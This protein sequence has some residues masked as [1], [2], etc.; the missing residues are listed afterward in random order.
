MSGVAGRPLTRAASRATV[1]RPVKVRLSRS[2][3]IVPGFGS[4]TMTARYRAGSMCSAALRGGYHATWAS[5][6]S[7][8]PP[9]R[10]ATTAVA[11]VMLYAQAGGRTGLMSRR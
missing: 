11:T 1:R 7:S 2:G 3:L 4:M 9:P 10:A 6:R 5:T 8:E